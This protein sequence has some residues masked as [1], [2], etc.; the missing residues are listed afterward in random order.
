VNF[1][2]G[3]QM[4]G[5]LGSLIRTLFGGA[6]FVLASLMILVSMIHSKAALH[7]YVLPAEQLLTPLNIFC[8]V[9]FALIPSGMLA[10]CVLLAAFAHYY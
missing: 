8:L 2:D 6:S 1:S 4:S 9:L 5:G 10:G 7:G 3:N